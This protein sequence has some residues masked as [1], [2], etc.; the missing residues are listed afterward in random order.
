MSRANQVDEL[1]DG[2]VSA[3]QM[4]GEQLE[5]NKTQQEEKDKELAAATKTRKTR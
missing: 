3:Q 1:K 5:A 4:N 2:L